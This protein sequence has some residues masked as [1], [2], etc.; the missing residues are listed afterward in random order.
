MDNLVFGAI[1]W[2][3]PTKGPGVSRTRG[4][5]FRLL[6]SHQLTRFGAQNG[7]NNFQDLQCKN[8]CLPNHGRFLWLPFKIDQESP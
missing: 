2:V 5:I 7:S 8:V 6:P 1:W 3:V 4:P